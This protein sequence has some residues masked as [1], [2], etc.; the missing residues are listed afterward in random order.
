MSIR[1]YRKATDQGTVTY[2]SSSALVEALRGNST[3]RGCMWNEFEGGSGAMAFPR[4]DQV[5]IFVRQ[6]GS[7]TEFRQILLEPSFAVA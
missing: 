5:V 1:K 4:A 6:A 2:A 7:T 3:F